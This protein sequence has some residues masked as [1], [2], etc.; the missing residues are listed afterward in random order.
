MSAPFFTVIIPVY[1]RVDLVRRA[2]ESVLAQDDGDFEIVVV[3]SGSTDGTR[4]LLRDYAARDGRVRLVF[5]EARR[6]VCPAR[7]LGVD[8]ARAEWLVMLDSDDELAGPQTLRMIRARVEKWGSEVA[9]F[10]FMCV[11]DDGSLSP[12]P[13]LRDETWDYVGFVRF[14]DD[15]AEGGRVETLSC[16]RRSTFAE[17]R[18]PEDR[19]Y[20]TLYN[21]EFAQR[22]RT[23]ACSD[24]A[25]RYHT[26]AA[27][28]NSFAP[29]PQHWLRVAPDHAR[30]LNAVVERHGAALARHGP[31][32][33]G[34]LLRSA[35]KFNFL[36]GD[37]ATAVRLLLRF[38]RRRPFMP[39]S[40]GVAVLGML[41]P[42]PLAWADA[43]RFA[44]HQRK[45]AR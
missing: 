14:L 41:G 1:N 26:D 27:D 22:F 9:K 18:Y 20:E 31:H 39:L 21:F 12:Q 16:V 8:H 10:R 33:Y 15:T 40:W 45:V 6:G 17:V 29:N 32:A 7:N 38:W 4:E 43:R 2:M 35:A 34:E 23:R 19:S 25:R 36:A 30:S 44:M 42:R 11:W 28:Q 3:D 5:E 24:V 13:P 37:R